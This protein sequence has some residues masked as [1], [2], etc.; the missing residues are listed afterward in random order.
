NK[1]SVTRSQLVSSKGAFNIFGNIKL[2]AVLSRFIM[3][4]YKSRNRNSTS[5]QHSN[6]NSSL[7][8][9]ASS[10]NNGASYNLEYCTSSSSLSPF[11]TRTNLSSVKSCPSS[12]AKTI[13]NVGCLDE[14]FLAIS[15][16]NSLS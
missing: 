13:I 4:F 3:D 2:T 5:S 16:S 8:S 14:V 10:S 15:N 11:G 7:K 12:S 9:H 6:S 1:I